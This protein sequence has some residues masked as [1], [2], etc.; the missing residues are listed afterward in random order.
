M[1]TSAAKQPPAL[2]KTSV[3]R[4]RAP[5]WFVAPHRSRNAVQGF[6]GQAFGNVKSLNLPVTLICVPFTGK[7]LPIFNVLLQITV[8]SKFEAD[9]SGY[10]Q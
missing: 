2:I 5:R 8:Y 1:R 4:H 7:E 3:I 10:S 6:S 9:Y